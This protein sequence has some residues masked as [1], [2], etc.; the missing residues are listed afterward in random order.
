MIMKGIGSLKKEKDIL[1]PKPKSI[2][3]GI[4][5]RISKRQCLFLGIRKACQLRLIVFVSAT[6]YL[7]TDTGIKPWSSQFEFITLIKNII[8]Q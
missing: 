1:C 6:N 2:T 8:P 7:P 3:F 4:W 5:V